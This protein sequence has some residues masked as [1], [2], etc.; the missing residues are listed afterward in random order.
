[1]SAH[2]WLRLTALACAFLLLAGCRGTGTEIIVGPPPEELQEEEDGEDEP[3]IA[4]PWDALAMD[5]FSNPRL[6]PVFF[7]ADE[8]EKAPALTVKDKEGRTRELDLAGY[9]EIVF[10]V[11]WSMDSYDTRAAIIH[12]DALAYRYGGFGVKGLSVVCNPQTYHHA[13]DFLQ[14]NHALLDNYYD[15]FS[16]LHNMADASG[17]DLHKELPCFFLIDSDGLI[18][19]AKLGFSSSQVRDGL[20]GAGRVRVIENA[21][22]GERIEDFLHRLLD[23]EELD[24]DRGARPGGVTHS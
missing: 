4:D 19:F 6:Q 13:S 23:E 8:A 24:S 9:D 1:M 17:K 11:F 7:D 20:P 22:R 16:A 3:V 21:P 5:D 18:R 10:L 14:T 15:D 2:K 12:A